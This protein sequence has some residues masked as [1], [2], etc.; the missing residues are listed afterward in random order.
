M[1]LVNKYNSEKVALER[2]LDNSTSFLKLI[3]ICQINFFGIIIV[4]QSHT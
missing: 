4:H 3:L 1:A 2:E